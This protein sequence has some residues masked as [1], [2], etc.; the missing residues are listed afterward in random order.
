[1]EDEI[2]LLTKEQV[3]NLDI[4][5]KYGKETEVTD[6]YIIQGGFYFDDERKGCYWTK[7]PSSCNFSDVLHVD[8]YGDVQISYAYNVS[9]GV[10]P[11]I[12]LSK[13][14][15]SEEELNKVLESN[16]NIVEYGEYP[17]TIV[18]CDLE[19][20]L[21]SLYRKKIL[22]K[23]EKVYNLLFDEQ[24]INYQ[25]YIYQNNKYIRMENKLD[26]YDS[27][28]FANGREL[29]EGETYWLKVE[30]IKWLIDK[31][32]KLAIANNVLANMP[33]SF[34]ANNNYEKSDVKIFLEKYFIKE[35]KSSINTKKLDNLVD[36]MFDVYVPKKKKVKQKVR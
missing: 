15:K 17:K 21:E 11:V 26:V 9:V 36:L 19:K 6:F 28:H 33:F 7:T 27:K 24:K 34:G 18:D 14:Y 1:M 35:I 3:E 4:L 5:K 22:L 10:R 31:K 16:R 20:K 30:P 25:E 32:E 29:M 12:P 8:N 23:T 13:I 2:T